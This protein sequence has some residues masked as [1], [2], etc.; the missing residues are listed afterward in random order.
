MELK[1]SAASP[2]APKVWKSSAGKVDGSN[3]FVLSDATVDRMG[4]IIDP[5]GW[6][7]DW[8]KRNS[9]ALFKHD[10]GFPIGTWSDPRI[11]DGRLIADFQPAQRGTSQRIDEIVS[12]VEQGILVATSVGFDPIRWEPI[13]QKA[14]HMGV[15][16]LEQELLEASIVSVPANPAAL[17]VAKN[18]SI[19]DA[20]LAI[21]F[22][23][24]A[25]I[26]R[27]VWVPGKPA[28]LTTAER[29][30]VGGP[31]YQ[32]PNIMSSTLS[33]RI[34]SAQLDL[35]ARKDRLTE[36]TLAE[37]LDVTAIEALNEEIEETERGLTALRTSESRI[38]TAATR[39]TGVAVVASPHIARQP[40]GFPRKEI[41]GF[42]LIVRA[43]TV[44]G[45]SAFGPGDKTLDRV[46]DERYPGHEQTAIVTKA[47]QT[48][49]TT[50]VS[51]WASEVVR[52]AYGDFLQA[53][54]G[55]SIYPAIRDRGIGLSF[56]GNG[57]VTIPSRTA[58]GAGGGFFAEGSPMRVGRIT[59][60]STTMTSKQMGVI[61]A[62]SRQLA[63][64]STPSIESL[65][66]QAVLE[67]TAAI[68][69]PIV[70]DA[71]VGDTARPAG[72]LYGVAAASTGYPGADYRAV[73]EDFKVLLA[74]FISANASDNITVVMNPSQGLGLS[75]MDAPV[76]NPNWFDG[77]RDRINIVESTH[78]VAGRLIAFRN[79]D[80][81]T[82]L[83]DA[84]EFDVSTSATLHMEDT[85]PL[86]I[87]SG[88]GPTVADP[89]RSLWQ[90]G[91]IGVR[92][93]M[94][95]GWAMRR[96]GVVQW[97]NGTSW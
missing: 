8:F 11:E 45:I 44:R 55:V 72:L 36:L 73:L 32:A 10:G 92:M 58:G 51:G 28:V 22:G 85:T 26:G 23:E 7:L 42:D 76:G 21:A 25:A 4:D 95:I 5:L 89:V 75:F 50:T 16:Y 12:L 13:D 27:R 74:P 77:I 46:L 37:E 87:V 94:D 71:T 48:I 88:T 20:T 82:A 81:A 18:L 2:R 57:S 43:I 33:K 9:I 41:N 53:L 62:F 70:L 93:I 15:K 39:E 83:G 52:T 3:T 47:D 91:T 96:A 68:L 31:L 69:D 6:R 24:S 59:T 49:G 90:T 97:I 19:S 14:P 66:R 30:R 80:F 38:G 61:V 84:P 56:D 86:E 35:V 34:E 29:T 40:L 64:K 65:V 54:T 63:M 67:D 1:T 60:A 79:S 17:H 78:A